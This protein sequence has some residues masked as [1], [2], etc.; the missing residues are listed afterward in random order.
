VSLSDVIEGSARWHI[1]CADSREFIKRIPD[2]S[3]HTI[4]CDPPYFISFLSA[5]WDSMKDQAALDPA[6]W[7]ECLR[8]LK[9]GGHLTAFGFPKTIHR[10]ATAIEDGGFELRDQISWYFGSSMPKGKLNVG[11]LIDEAAGLERPV[12]STYRV[13]GNALT[14]T[15]EKGGTYGVGVPNSP[16]GELAR[17]APVSDAA[18]QW[19]D[20]GALLKIAH[21]PIVL[22][23]KPFDCTLEMN[24]LAWGVG[25]LNFGA[26]RVPTDWNESDRG[27]SWKKSGHTKKPNEAKI[28]APPG[29]GMTLHPGGR[30]PP[31]VLMD[32][33]VAGIFD[34]EN[35]EWVSRYFPCLPGVYAPKASRK[36]RDAGLDGWPVRSAGT[37]TKRKE[38]SAGING[39]AGA[40]RTGG[41]RNPHETVKSLEVLRW[42]LR[43]TNPVNGIAF[44][45]FLGSGTMICA[46]VLE[47]MRAIGCER[48]CIPAMAAV[49]RVRHWEASLREVG[50]A[51][52]PPERLPVCPQ[53]TSLFEHAG[54]R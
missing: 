48:E 5:K 17:T 45:P 21:E 42:L 7:A 30:H 29:N 10:V 4:C 27:A 37:A 41:S 26:T 39:M 35:G 22:A 34:E 14:P 40:G 12:T 3:V 54:A 25:A 11:K 16:S 38:G 9:P 28:A 52:S 43:L 1:E 6:F 24:V 51:G 50:H 46:A 44:D 8:I 2:N 47:G 13:G 31:N 33:L 19:E 32:E 53:Q 23:R 36:E 18:R 49:D 15:S 20:W